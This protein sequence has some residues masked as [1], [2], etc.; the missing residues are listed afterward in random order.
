[1]YYIIFSSLVSHPARQCT[2]FSDAV[3]E[4]YDRQKKFKQDN[5]EFGLLPK[6]GKLQ[7]QFSFLF[8]F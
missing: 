5:E 4:A 2:Y 1:L 8:L 6:S 3:I 7:S